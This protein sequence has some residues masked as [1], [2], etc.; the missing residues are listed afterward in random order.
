MTSAGLNDIF[1]TSGD[2][3]SVPLR[4]DVLTYLH[5]FDAFIPSQF[6]GNFNEPDIARHSLILARLEEAKPLE[7]PKKT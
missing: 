4:I 6:K 5:F 2:Q 3:S 7:E 1:Y